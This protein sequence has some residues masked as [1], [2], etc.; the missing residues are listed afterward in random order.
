MD[1][2]HSDIIEMVPTFLLDRS[3]PLHSSVRLFRLLW[4]RLALTSTGKGS[5][6]V[7]TLSPLAPPS[8]LASC[9]ENDPY[10][11][12]KT[13]RFYPPVSFTKITGISEIARVGRPISETPPH[14]TAYS[15]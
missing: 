7:V 15:M 12:Y 1:G 13:G 9:R 11:N 14:C 10:I 3:R 8:S 5:P 2:G 6:K 4:V